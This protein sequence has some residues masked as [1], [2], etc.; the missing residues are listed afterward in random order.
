MTQLFR[1]FVPAAAVFVAGC[2]KTPAPEPARAIVTIDE[3]P[4]WMQVAAEADL[5]RLGRAKDAWSEGLAAAR[6]GGFTSRVREEGRLLEP[7]AA[8]PRPQPSPGSYNCRV[9]KLGTPGRGRAF[10]SYKPFFC[11]VGVE[12]DLLSITKQGG[13]ERPGGYLWEDSDPRRMIF[14]GSMALGDEEAPAAYG[15]NPERDMVGHFERV[16]HFRY[17]LVVPWP[18]EPAK[19]IVIELKPAP[20]QP[21]EQD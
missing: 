19:L 20:V 13:S 8:L 4:E 10:Q 17:R 7:D 11:Y 1:V 16:G 18:R 21:E 15:D 9:L 12:E 3:D 2:E 5:D 14:L 6:A